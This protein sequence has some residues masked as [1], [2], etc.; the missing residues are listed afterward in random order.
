MTPPTPDTGTGTPDD[1]A[2]VVVDPRLRAR[3]IAVR[4]DVGRRRLHR[5][6]VLIVAAALALT[7]VIV[8]KSPILDVDEIEIHGAQATSVEAITDATGV[9]LG[10][11]LL[12]ADLEAAQRSIEALPWIEEAT[13]SRDLPGGVVVDVIERTPSAV[14]ASGG[15]A[16]LV[17]PDGHV[18][19]VADPARYPDAVPTFPPFVRVVVDDA[20]EAATLPGPGGRVDASLLDAIAIAERVRGNPANVVAAVHLAPTL[21]LELAGGGIVDFGDGDGIDA[22]IDAF[23]TI[24]A[25]V[26]QTCIDVLDLRVPT[27][28]VLTRDEPCS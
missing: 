2:D 27:R 19:S 15:S 22:K 23:R 9:D 6:I 18:L 21:R 26:D 25:R 11:A 7:T 5:L 12:L 13:V 20:P 14:V 4:R 1:L 3:R 28:P 24:H 10:S 8:L 17:D 16:V